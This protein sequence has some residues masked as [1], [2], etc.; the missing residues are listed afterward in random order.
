VEGLDDRTLVVGSRVREEHGLLPVQD[1][2][3]RLRDPDPLSDRAVKRRSVHGE[4]ELPVLQLLDAVR[5]DARIGERE[6]GGRRDPTGEARD[7][8]YLP[9]DGLVTANGMSSDRS[10]VRWAIA[11]PP[12]PSIPVHSSGDSGPSTP[13]VRFGIRRIFCVGRNYAAHAV[14]MG[15]DPDREPPFF[16]AKPADAAFDASPGVQAAIP[17]P[18]DTTDLNHEVEL[19]VA[20]GLGGRD[21]PVE[22]ALDHVYGYAVALDLTRRDRQREAKAAGR[23]WAMSKGFDASAPIGQLRPASEVGHPA[24]GR[25]WLAVDGTLRQD[26]DLDAMI[27]KAPEVVATL[28]RTVALAPGDLVLTGTPAGVGA[29]EPGQHVTA[30][31]EGL[32]D[33]SLRVGV[34]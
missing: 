10:D 26:A 24:S 8:E 32:S 30:G 34:P 15:G 6:S 14:E 5:R 3:T 31:I 33:L 28:S 4:R 23:P 19:C 2:L 9:C 13:Q 20:I 16:F 11:P 25:I 18:P 21:I 12:V 22:T 17:Y 27:W 1:H 29:I 7:Q